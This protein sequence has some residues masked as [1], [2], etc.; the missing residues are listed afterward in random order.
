MLGS[1]TRGHSRRSRL[2]RQ[3]DV[4]DAGASERPPEFRTGLAR[5]WLVDG[6]GAL[7]VDR[8]AALGA[9]RAAH[10]RGRVLDR[11]IFGW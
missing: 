8:V 4:D 11:Q 6:P 10:R 7:E 2:R 5:R 1:D 9:S 3:G